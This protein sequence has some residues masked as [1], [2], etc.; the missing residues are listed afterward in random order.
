MLLLL[1]RCV[2]K[3]A[4]EWWKNWEEG[5]GGGGGGGVLTFREEGGA[6]MKKIQW[7]KIDRMKKNRVEKDRHTRGM[8]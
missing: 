8:R 1:L 3:E 4:G 5:G 2:F 7:R 6:R